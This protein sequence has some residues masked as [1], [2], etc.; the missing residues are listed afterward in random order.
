MTFEALPALAPAHFFALSAPLAHIG[1]GLSARSAY[2]IPLTHELLD[3]EKFADVYG[4]WSLDGLSFLVEASIP[5]QSENDTVEF[6]IDTR[7]LKSRSILS[8]FCHHFLFSLLT[9]EGKE[10]T[11]M[12]QEEFHPLA[13]PADLVPKVDTTPRSWRLFVKIP[14][15]CLYGYDPSSFPRL[16]FT[17]RIRR[18]GGPSQHFSLSS[19]EV[20]IENHPALWATLN[21][22]AAT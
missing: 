16:G 6:W 8:R 5:C 1:K 12:R 20:S 2:A 7:D 18:T 21:L 13:D 4:A 10:I 22:E 19:E 15:S 3:E 17:Y 9:K 14:A 11:R